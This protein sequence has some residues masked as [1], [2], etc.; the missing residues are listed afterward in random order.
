MFSIR[1]AISAVALLV[2]ASFFSPV[3]AQTKLPWGENFEKEE[4]F[5]GTIWCDAR[6][7]AYRVYK[8]TDIA[9]TGITI[10]IK[11]VMRFYVYSPNPD[12]MSPI[13]FSYSKERDGSYREVSQGERNGLLSIEAP[14]L[15]ALFHRQTHDCIADG[16]LYLK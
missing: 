2:A 15:Y 1:T 13:T 10:S 16:A 12:S 14:N 7:T 8:G 5:V 6:Q 11:G 3:F 4:F 9:F